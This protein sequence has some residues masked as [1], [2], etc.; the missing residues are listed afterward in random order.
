MKEIR[1][2]RKESDLAGFPTTFPS[3]PLGLAQGALAAHNNAPLPSRGATSPTARGKVQGHA[4]T[5]WVD[6]QEVIIQIT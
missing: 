4:V 3:V 5:S 1:F 2:T 6:G